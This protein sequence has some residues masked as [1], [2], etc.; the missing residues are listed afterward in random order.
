[1]KQLLHAKIGSWGTKAIFLGFL[2][3][4]FLLYAPIWKQKVWNGEN[5]LPEK[6]VNSECWP[7][8]EAS[9]AFMICLNK[10]EFLGTSSDP[11]TP[12]SGLERQILVD[13]HA[14]QFADKRWA[15][16]GRSKITAIINRVCIDCKVKYRPSPVP[17]DISGLA[18]WTELRGIAITVREPS[19]SD[20]FHSK[21]ENAVGPHHRVQLI[22]QGVFP[23]L[24]P[25]YEPSMSQEFSNAFGE[26]TTI[27]FLPKNPK[28]ELDTQLLVNSESGQALLANI[29]LKSF[30]PFGDEN[31]ALVQNCV[32]N[33]LAHDGFIGEFR[34][35]LLYFVFK[36]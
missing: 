23:I 26:P 1:M 27:V 28:C 10:L 13:F 14:P 21:T 5:L 19:F 3:L 24:T 30:D 12:K 18:K 7:N 17:G 4:V 31:I 22:D 33:F 20:Q 25:S 11:R 32:G 9:V 36:T 29:I 15:E 35:P 2:S 16:D 6:F 8:A 34:L